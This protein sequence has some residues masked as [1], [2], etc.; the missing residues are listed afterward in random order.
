M[1]RRI[2]RKTLGK[3][4]EIADT[5]IKVKD[6]YIVIGLTIII[7]LIFTILKVNLFGF[8]F[9]IIAAFTNLIFTGYIAYFLNKKVK[10]NWLKFKFQ[11]LIRKISGVGQNIVRSPSGRK[12]SNFLPDF[13]NQEKP[14]FIINRK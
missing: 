8:P 14:N 5:G 9:G 7:F 3:P 4:I 13:N 6:L 1:R 12:E 11:T 10:P 2:I